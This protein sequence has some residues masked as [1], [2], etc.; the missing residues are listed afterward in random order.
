MGAATFQRVGCTSLPPEPQGHPGMA[1]PVTENRFLPAHTSPR[2]RRGH[3]WACRTGRGLGTPHPRRHSATGPGL[4]QPYPCPSVQDTILGGAMEIP[5]QRALGRPLPLKLV[6]SQLHPL[7]PG[8]RHQLLS[9]AA[10]FREKQLPPET[11]TF[12][13]QNAPMCMR[14]HPHAHRY[15]HTDLYT[16]TH[17]HAAHKPR[18]FTEPEIAPTHP[19][20]VSTSKRD[21]FI[22]SP[23][24]L[25]SKEMKARFCLR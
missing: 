16:H 23:R 1:D 14:T 11:Y 2:E 3:S 12:L 4:A 10:A 7:R 20:N 25:S 21:W 15:G 17:T 19:E 24:G 8:F 5:K 13:E 22:P 6:P 18:G 9:K